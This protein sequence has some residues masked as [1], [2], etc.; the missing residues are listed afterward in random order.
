[1]DLRIPEQQLRLR[2]IVRIANQPGGKVL[3]LPLEEIIVHVHITSAMSHGENAL[4]VFLEPAVAAVRLL[5]I[6]HQHVEAAESAVVL[7]APGCYGVGF[8]V[9]GDGSGFFFVVGEV[10]YG[11]VVLW[12]GC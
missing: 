11:A 8:L 6:G 1:M 10:G 7:V 9:V 5:A 3:V 2:H 12:V 4:A